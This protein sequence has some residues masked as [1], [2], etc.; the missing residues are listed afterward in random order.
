MARVPRRIDVIGS[1]SP[2]S[3]LA[4]RRLNFAEVLAQS[5]AAVAPSAAA[6]TIPV[7][8]IAWAGPAAV[9][10]FV[11]ASVLMLMVGYCVTQFA[12]RMTSASGVYSYTAKGLGPH[13]AFTVGWSLVIGYGG[14]AMT[15]AL[16]G[17]IYLSTL[18]DTVG[19]GSFRGEW[20]IAGCSVAVAVAAGLLMVRGIQL[21]ARVS[22]S[23]EVVSV[24][25][26]AAILTL[27]LVASSSSS[28]SPGSVGGTASFDTV[29]AGLLLAAM[30]F[31]GFESAS[32]LGV[33]VRRPFVTV[34]RTLL[35]TPIA[36]A[37]LYV[38]AVSAQSW[39]FSQEPS[40]L[41]DSPIPIAELAEDRHRAALAILLDVGIFSSWFACLMGSTNALVRVLFSMGREGVLPR[42]L[43]RTHHRYRTPY[44]AI[45]IAVPAV[46]TAPLAALAG[47]W[48][49]LEILVGFLTLSAYGYLLSYA[50]L[51]IATPVFLRRLGELTLMPLVVGVL[52]FVVTVFLIA[53]TLA[54]R[55]LED[56]G[57]AAAYLVLML[58]GGARLLHLTVRDRA[59]LHD[60][61]VYD[62]PVLGDMV[63]DDAGWDQ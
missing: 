59:R 34:P 5:V 29:T 36:L 27:M 53:W 45:A 42:P 33:E 37:V 49:L 44:V 23:L 51:C 31:V 20:A 24:A 13:A 26:V 56:G 11:A 58:L 25:I 16:A 22:L 32:T 21:S 12:R 57:V 46:T 9:P 8:V 15:S 38:F 62:E 41:L 1:E 30:C 19:P 2:L 18:L 48:S 10:I 60:I 3:G 55:T 4:R 61:G 14:A 43:G 50:L 40:S 17:G 54:T 39:I 7:I 35:W 28:A 63:D 52:A 6:V 47:S